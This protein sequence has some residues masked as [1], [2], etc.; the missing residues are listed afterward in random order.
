MQHLRSIQTADIYFDTNRRPVLITCDDMESYVCKY[1]TGSGNSM[2][3]FC[4]YLASAFLKIWGLHTPDSAF[5]RINREHIPSS[6]VYMAIALTRPVLQQNI[7]PN[8]LT[9]QS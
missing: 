8:M 1:H 2:S 9:Q 7:I 6:W 3:L 4:E 5:V